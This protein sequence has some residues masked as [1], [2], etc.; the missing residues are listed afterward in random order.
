MAKRK[1]TILFIGWMV[2]IT[3]LS[4][5]SFSSEEE[6]RIWFPNL[7]KVVHFTFHFVIL[8]LG[9][10]FLNETT[11]QGWDWKKKIRALFIFSIT[12]GLLIEVL[13]WLMPFDRSAEVWDVLANLGGATM[14]GLLIQKNRSLIDRLK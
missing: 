12:Y 6:D 5:F 7:D 1:F 2:L 10:L 9:V 8:V 13:Q 3:S 11:S 4:L 14:G